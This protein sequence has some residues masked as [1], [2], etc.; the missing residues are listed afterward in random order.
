MTFEEVWNGLKS[1]DTT[2]TFAKAEELSLVSV[3]AIEYAFNSGYA[4]AKAE[5]ERPQGEW[6]NAY[7]GDLYYTT[8]Y[9]CSKCGRKVKIEYPDVISNY[10]FCHCGA[11]MRGKEE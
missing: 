7:E 6:I 4:E 5:F 3:E 9:K 2:G 1:K 11:D 8:V 10:P